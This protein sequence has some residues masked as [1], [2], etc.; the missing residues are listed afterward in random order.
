MLI[1][2]PQASGAQAA[3]GMEG[4]AKGIWVAFNADCLTYNVSACS[5][6]FN[7]WVASNHT[8]ARTSV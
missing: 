7:E 1:R 2:L 6:H 8:Q 5:V 3:S 4:M